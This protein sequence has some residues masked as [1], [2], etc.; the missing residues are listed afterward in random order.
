MVV[1]PGSNVRSTIDSDG[2]ILLNLSTGVVFR[3]NAVG[4]KI[5]QMIEQGMTIERIL[6]SLVSQYAIPLEQAEKD[7]REFLQQLKIKELIR[8]SGS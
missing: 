6:D 3:I 1:T 8:D 2:G 7:A 5:W 4:A